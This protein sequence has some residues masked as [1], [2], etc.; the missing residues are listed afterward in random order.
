MTRFTIAHAKR[1]RKQP[2]RQFKGALVDR[3][4]IALP[5]GSIVTTI[6]GGAGGPPG[7]PLAP[8]AGGPGAAL[9]PG[10]P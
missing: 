3:L 5:E 10:W 2:E 9:S 6:P 8:G 4:R 7:A 1:K